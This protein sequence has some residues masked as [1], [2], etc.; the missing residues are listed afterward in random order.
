MA[1][2]TGMLREIRRRLDKGWDSR[3]PKLMKKEGDG[4]LT[5]SVIEKALAAED[6]LMHKV[7]A[8]AQYYLGLA[9]GSLANLLDPEV[10]V[11]GGG[12]AERLGEGFVAPIRAHAYKH[13][14]VQRERERVQIV[15][16][17]LKDLAA[18]LGAA[19][20]AR[21]RLAEPPRV[22]APTQ[23]N[24]GSEPVDSAQGARHGTTAWPA[25]SA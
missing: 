21:Q 11:I 24:D 13:F 20:L 14:L 10:I 15:P 9:A 16:T 4:E 1:S 18:P 22:S 19:F 7:M 12:V 2:R 23:T 6:P 5:S 25:P 17:A 8:D 3:L